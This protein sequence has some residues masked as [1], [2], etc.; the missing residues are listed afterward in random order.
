MVL[1]AVRGFMKAFSKE[2]PQRRLG[3]K[4]VWEVAAFVCSV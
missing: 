1:L 3:Y 2:N 4:D